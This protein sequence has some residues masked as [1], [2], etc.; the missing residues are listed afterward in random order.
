MAL[1]FSAGFWGINLHLLADDTTKAGI[2]KTWLAANQGIGDGLP[3][4]RRIRDGHCENS[5]VCH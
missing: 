3:G 4:L 5:K 1:P 2:A